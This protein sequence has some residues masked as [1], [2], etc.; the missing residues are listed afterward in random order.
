[1]HN[2]LV[3]I[4][5]I[6]FLAPS[7]SAFHLPQFRLSATPEPVHHDL[8]NKCTFTLWH[9]QTCFASK[10]TNYVQMFEIKDH[11]NNITIDVAALRPSAS[12]NSYIKISPHDVFAVEGLLD[13]KSLIIA[14]LPSEGDDI[15]FLNDDAI[16]SSDLELNSE[17]AWCV[18][19]QWDNNF[20]EC[21]KGSRVSRVNEAE[22]IEANGN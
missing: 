17:E 3:V 13:D 7:S 16:F 21:G 14:D 5:S 15:Y 1:M 11:A 18:T 2:A 22:C 12:H 9:K 19:S 8:T 6:F 4:A 20:R 10:K